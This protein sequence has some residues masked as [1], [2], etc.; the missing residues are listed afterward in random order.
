MSERKPYLE[1]SDKQKKRRLDK[2]F[3][4]SINELLCA[5]KNRLSNVVLE[6]VVASN[7]D[8]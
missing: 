3:E 1:L 7:S 8:P 4:N 2:A 6:S 5:N